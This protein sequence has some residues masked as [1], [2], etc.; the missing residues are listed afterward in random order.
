MPYGRPESLLTLK[1]SS[2]PPRII[3]VC[4][5]AS[6]LEETLVLLRVLGKR[7][8]QSSTFV[9]AVPVDASR[10]SDWGISKGTY[11]WLAEAYDIEEWKG[12]FDHLSEGSSDF[13][14]FGLNS[15]GRSFGSGSGESPQWLQ[16]LGQYLRPTEMLYEQDDDAISADKEEASIVECQR[17][18]YTALTTGDQEVIAAVYSSEK[19]SLVSE[20]RRRSSDKHRVHCSF[21][22]LLSLT[23]CYSRRSHGGLEGMSRG[24][25]S[26]PWDEGFWKRCFGYFR[27]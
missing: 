9:V 27:L 12:F 2:S 15:N 7:L 5:T 25:C 10:R 13:R 23:G 17:K 21:N 1:R 26:P 14:W 11:P 19:S 18:F 3:A 8:K 24:W 4:G 22:T 20:V 16:V 6:Q